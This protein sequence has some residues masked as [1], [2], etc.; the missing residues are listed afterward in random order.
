MLFGFITIIMLS[1][2]EI[3]LHVEY[4]LDNVSQMIVY[5]SVPFTSFRLFRVL[6]DFCFVGVHFHEF[7]RRIDYVACPSV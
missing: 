3:G 4:S 6:C 5:F 1:S 7:S 2:K